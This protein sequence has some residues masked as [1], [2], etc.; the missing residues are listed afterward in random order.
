MNKILSF[1]LIGIV[2]LISSCSQEQEKKAVMNTKK[3]DSVKV[4]KNAAQTYIDLQKKR[5]DKAKASVE[6]SKKA[7]E[8]QKKEIDNL[9]GN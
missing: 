3:T 7:T 5:M 4:E 8:A 1:M 9:L 6:K 2:L